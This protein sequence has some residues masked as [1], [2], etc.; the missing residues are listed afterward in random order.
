MF[1]LS[2]IVYDIDLEYLQLPNCS[3]YPGP[4]SVLILD[5]AK[6]HHGGELQELADHFGVRIE[7]LPPY[8]PDFNPIEEAFSKIKHFLRRHQVYYERQGDGIFYDMFEV[9]EIVTGDDAAGYFA[10]AGYF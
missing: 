1:P 2:R 4:L 5:N 3:P 7:Y 8:S 6:I 9:M 10:N